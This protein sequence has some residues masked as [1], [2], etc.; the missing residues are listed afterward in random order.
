MHRIRQIAVVRP[1]NDRGSLRILY[2]NIQLSDLSVFDIYHSR[3]RHNRQPAHSDLHRVQHRNTTMFRCR[4]R[5]N[6]IIFP[7]FQRYL[8]FY[9][10]SDTHR[11]FHHYGG[12]IPETVFHAF[13][14][15]LQ[16]QPVRSR[17]I[18]AINPG[19]HQRVALRQLLDFHFLPSEITDTSP[20]IHYPDIIDSLFYAAP[21]QRLAVFRRIHQMSVLPQC[22]T[23]A[24]FK[25]IVRQYDIALAS[26]AIHTV[27]VPC[28]Q[29]A[30]LRIRT[31]RNTIQTRQRTGTPRRRIHR[32]YF[33]ESGTDRHQQRI[34]RSCIRRL[35][36]IPSTLLVF[37]QIIKHAALASGDGQ[38]SGRISHAHMPFH[39]QSVILRQ[40]IFHDLRCSGHAVLTIMPVRSGYIISTCRQ[41]F[42]N[43]MS[44]HRH[45]IPSMNLPNRNILSL[46]V[47][48]IQS[49]GIRSQQ[50]SGQT[51]VTGAIASPSDKAERIGITYGY[52][53]FC[54]IVAT[55]VLHMTNILSGSIRLG[56][57]N[58][59]D[60]R[61]SIRDGIAVMSPDIQDRRS[62]RRH[63]HQCLGG[64]QTH[65]QFY[66]PVKSPDEFGRF[67][68][69]EAHRQTPVGTALIHHLHHINTFRILF[70]HSVYLELGRTTSD[71]M[72]GGIIHKRRPFIMPADA[73]QRPQRRNICLD[74]HRVSLTVIRF[75]IGDAHQ[76]RL[77]GYLHLYRRTGHRI[78][79][80]IYIAT[81]YTRIG[82]L[83]IADVQGRRSL[84]VQYLIVFLPII[85]ITGISRSLTGKIQRLSD[86]QF[87]IFGYTD[88]RRPF[89]NPQSYKR[90][91]FPLSVAAVIPEPP[92]IFSGR[93]HRNADL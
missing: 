19:A 81:I 37:Q 89:I 14:A 70:L 26:A 15:V 92:D 91:I 67:L 54:N 12:E 73:I 41:I 17:L 77:I 5:R 6:H 40:R 75:Y 10:P 69:F 2:Q 82:S 45:H 16:I 8:Q 23:A 3:I 51:A 63:H 87:L 13:L 47:Q 28:P 24:T 25:T 49:R 29:F 79:F 72:A 32:I 43:D 64:S 52:E 84:A 62:S 93:I 61:I 65:D 90:R 44:P 66:I 38:I 55:S 68:Q 42:K 83:D 58:R 88:K 71:D 7:L 36:C 56:I 57:R 4:I 11:I 1:R 74:F 60:I 31:G 85:K 53:R 20:L 30:L 35:Q 46:F 34:S 78:T 9:F 27:I 22:I 21:S 76:L 18:L 48:A 33:I 39:I 86:T 59:K 50:L 80:I